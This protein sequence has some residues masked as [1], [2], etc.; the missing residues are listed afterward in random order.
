MAFE[1]H[2]G[3]KPTIKLKNKLFGTHFIKEVENQK[4]NYTITFEISHQKKFLKCH[5]RHK[6]LP[7]EAPGT[8]S[9]H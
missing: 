1:A 2:T 4:T 8:W 3:F 6:T 5:S 7:G 9:C